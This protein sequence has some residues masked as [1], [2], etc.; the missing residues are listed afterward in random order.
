MKLPFLSKQNTFCVMALGML[1]TDEKWN[2]PFEATFRK[3]CSYSSGKKQNKTDFIQFI[4]K[5]ETYYSCLTASMAVFLL[6]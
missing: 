3:K 1:Q 5:I 2:E 4:K 6:Y